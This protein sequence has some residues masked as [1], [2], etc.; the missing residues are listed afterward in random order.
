MCTRQSLR[1]SNRLP[2]RQI[3]ILST[4][5]LS[6]K[7]NSHDKSLTP[8][9][10]ESKKLT[11]EQTQIPDLRNGLM[12]LL[13][14]RRRNVSARG[15]KIMSSDQNYLATCPRYIITLELRKYTRESGLCLLTVVGWILDDLKRRAVC[16]YTRRRWLAFAIID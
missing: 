9:L 1:N 3:N 13:L 10:A 16:L 6:R 5:E 12:L 15:P 11:V 7:A 8:E 2:K 14:Y 4:A